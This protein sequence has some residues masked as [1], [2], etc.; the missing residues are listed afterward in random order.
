MAVAGSFVLEEF[1]R[2]VLL[3]EGCGSISGEPWV[4]GVSEIGLRCLSEDSIVDD[5]AEI[6]VV[7]P[8]N[9]SQ[10]VWK[11]KDVPGGEARPK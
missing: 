5:V 4:P 1:V 10:E 3:A 6:V 2:Y 7:D 8:D 11:L 9:E